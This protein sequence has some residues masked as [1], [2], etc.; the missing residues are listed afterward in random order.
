MQHPVTYE[1]NK[2]FD[3]IN[4]TLSAIDELNIQTIWFWPNVDA[5]SDDSSRAIRIF[6]EKK[7]K[8]KI[9]FVK[10]L[11]P[12]EFLILLKSSLCLVGN[13]SVGIRECSYLGVPV[14]NIG[15]RQDGRKRGKNVLDV[16]YN[17]KSIKNGILE[18]IH[19]KK[20]KKNT[21]YGDGVAGKFI[22]DILSK[23]ELISEKKITY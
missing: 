1:W 7:I 16:S 20:F 8:N 18:Q 12:E 2:A 10:N 17:K 11:P 19:K 3:Q 5:G 4:M 6:R 13:S 9:R 21:I 14:V 22:A 23:I 15:T